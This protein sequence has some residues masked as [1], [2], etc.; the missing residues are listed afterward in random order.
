MKCR[1]S[2]A[3]WEQ[4]RD[5]LLADPEHP[6]LVAQQVGMDF[7]TVKRAWSLGWSEDNYPPISQLHLAKIA[8]NQAVTRGLVAE[9]LRQE[10]VAGGMLHVD[11]I[12]VQREVDQII[13]AARATAQNIIDEAELKAVGIV[14][15]V[16]E[17]GRHKK[18]EMEL[19]FRAKFQQIEQAIKQRIS[20]LRSAAKMDALE[21]RAQEAITVRGLKGN[22]V[23]ALGVI[24]SLLTIAGPFAEKLTKYFKSVVEDTTAMTPHEA[25]VALVNLRELIKI[26][27]DVNTAT[28]EAIRA[29]HLILGKPTE[30]LGSSDGKGISPEKA[31]HLIG[32][33]E[34]SIERL[35]NRQPTVLGTI[36]LPAVPAGSKNGGAN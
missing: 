15:Q 25:H 11:S 19:E 8:Q 7:S 2:K 30:I 21:A 33:A 18:A 34:R 1:F 32:V 20:D 27:K 12:N 36:G 17:E 4:L 9:V 35:T 16:D 3:R 24:G 28:L 14:A 26:V 5:A 10:T 6:K 31:K 13:S 29:E 22:S 23:R